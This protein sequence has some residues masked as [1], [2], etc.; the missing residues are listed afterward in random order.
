MARRGSTA[1]RLIDR[2]YRKAPSAIH[3]TTDTLLA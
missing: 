3:S 2:F 1:T